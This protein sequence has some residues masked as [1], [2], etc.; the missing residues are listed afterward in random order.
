MKG[1]EGH[2]RCKSCQLKRGDFDVSDTHRGSHLLEKYRGKTIADIIAEK[3]W[4][5]SKMAQSRLNSTPNPD[6]SPRKAPKMITK[7]SSYNNSHDNNYN[8]NYNNS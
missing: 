2:K 6:E 1:E 7:V 8:N 4:T 3:K 5:V